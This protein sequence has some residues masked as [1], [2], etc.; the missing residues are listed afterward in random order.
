[1]KILEKLF[2]LTGICANITIIYTHYRFFK[3][4]NE[5]D[6]DRIDLKDRDVEIRYVEEVKQDM[7]ENNMS[8]EVEQ[9]IREVESHVRDDDERV[10]GVS[11][12]DREEIEIEDRLRRASDVGEGDM[13]GEGGSWGKYLSFGVK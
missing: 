5:K 1:M 9:D 10:E 11:G 8:G 2:L 6:G 4:A 3:L 12:E 7:G 13:E